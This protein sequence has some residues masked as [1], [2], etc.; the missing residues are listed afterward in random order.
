[1]SMQGITMSMHKHPVDK[2][3]SWRSILASSLTHDYHVQE[4]SPTVE[5]RLMV[6]R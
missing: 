5:R 3:P 6:L 2:S 4:E 1:M